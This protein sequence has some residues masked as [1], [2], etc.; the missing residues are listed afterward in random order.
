[1]IKALFKEGFFYLAKLTAIGYILHMCLILFAYKSHPKF[2]LILAANRDEFYERPTGEAFWRG[3]KPD[4]LAGIDH[5]AGGTWMGMSECGRFAALTN[6]RN[7]ADM[8]PH[9]ASRG[10]LVYEFLSS[11]IDAESYACSLNESASQYNGYNLIFGTVDRLTYYSNKTAEDI[12]LN[13]GIYGLSNH[14][15]DTPWVKVQKGKAGLTEIINNEFTEEDLFKLMHDE[16]RADDKDLP[17]TGVGIEKERMLSPMF[18]K[19]D[20]YGTRCSTVI[21]VSKNGDVTFTERTYGRA[22]TSDVKY[23]FNI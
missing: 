11:G 17:E 14:L 20:N 12:P 1:M 16:Q 23:E 4:I 3:T 19:S 21:L 22:G 13:K 7:P 10:K 6:Y 9:R 18:I 8:S 2:D 5:H 15:L